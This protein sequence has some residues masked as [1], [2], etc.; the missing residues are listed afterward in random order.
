[1]TRVLSLT[2]A[3]FVATTGAAQTEPKQPPKAKQAPK[4]AAG[5]PPTQANVPYGKHPRQVLDF[6]QAKS[7]S[8]T[9]VVFAIH[10]GGWRN[11]DKGG[12]APQAK[13]FIDAGISVVAINYRLTP[14]ATEK[15]VEPPV[16]W[17]IDGRRPGAAVRPVE[18][19][20]V[21][22]RQ[23]P[24]RRDRRLGR[25][26]L[27]AV[28][29]VPRRPGRPEEC[30]PGRPRID[31]ADLRRRDRAADD[32]RPEGAPRVDAERT[33]TAG[34]PSASATKEDRDGAFQTFHEQREKLLPWIK[35]YSPITHVTKDDPPVF[36]EYPT[37][38]KPPVKGE[39]QDDPT[40]SALLGMILMEK[41]KDGG[42]RGD[43]RLPRARRTRSTRTPRTT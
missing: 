20:G 25:R 8:P 14:E 9:P 12:Y 31:P 1:M 6:Y 32:P 38:K 43:P 27:V 23:D 3:L 28:A 33:G 19:E 10:G 22:P 5:I 42:R 36:M 18:G 29:G 15:G 17:P 30:R 21:E 41:L 4:K 7:D 26:V 35:E 16:K 24:H 37:Q 13:R 11:G 40:H 39:E 2:V 34:T